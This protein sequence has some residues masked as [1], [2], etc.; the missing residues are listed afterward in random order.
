M[1]MKSVSK[2][3]TKEPTITDVMGAVQDL[4]E[5]VQTGFA[6]N[7]VKHDETKHS[8]DDLAYR[9]TALEKRTSAV[10]ETI[11]EVKVTLNG[12][13]RAVD[14]DAV[15]VLDHERRISRIEK[16]APLAA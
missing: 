5:A 13:A 6:K 4:T 14:K 10:E 3:S 11:E 16:T 12:V 2:S 1:R 9:V 15:T 7:E 8:I